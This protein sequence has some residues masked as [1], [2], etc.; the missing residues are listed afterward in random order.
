MQGSTETV[1]REIKRREAQLRNRREKRGILRLSA[2]TGMLLT[3]LTLC[4]VGWSRNVPGL[5]RPTAYGSILL[6]EGAGGYVLVSM[7]AFMAGVAVTVLCIRNRGKHQASNTHKG[8][9][10]S[11]EK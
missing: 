1:L 9:E 11:E 4:V 8:G 10:Q 2:Y 3:V 5:M 6:V 7:I